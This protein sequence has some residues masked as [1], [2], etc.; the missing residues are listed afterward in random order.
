MAAQPAQA[1]ASDLPLFG[2]RPVPD[3][4]LRGIERFLYWEAL[5]LDD[6]RYEEWLELFTDD[7]HYWMPVR[8]DKPKTAN[9]TEFAAND[10]LAFF[11][12]NKDTLTRRIAKLGTGMAWA[13]EP[14]SR[15]RH[16]VSNVLAD[17]G[18]S[19]AEAI[20]CS[21]FAVYRTRLE[22]KQDLLFGRR[23]DILRRVDGSW[24]IAR[25]KIL[26]DQTVLSADN[27]SLFF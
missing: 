9:L 11:D 13:E 21:N 24:K 5:L 7:V 23:D 18:E 17:W 2:S 15:T 19:D 20:V 4:V 26:L 8:R 27:L 10:E 25:R 1:F 14:P 16:V 22:T 3:D 6:R 12:E